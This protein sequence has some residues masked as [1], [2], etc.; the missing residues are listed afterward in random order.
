VKA[1]APSALAIRRRYCRRDDADIVDHGSAE[2]RAAGPE[3]G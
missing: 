3:R 1:G 2:D